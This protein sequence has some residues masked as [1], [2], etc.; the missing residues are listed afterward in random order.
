MLR[1]CDQLS[2][3]ACH[4]AALVE[5]LSLDDFLA[6]HFAQIPIRLGGRCGRFH[7]LLDW[8]ELARL[9]ETHPLDHS[10]LRLI[11]RGKDI[12]P[13]RY[14]R[15]LGGIARLDSGALSL[16]LD[17]GATLVVNHIDDLVPG[18]ASIADDVADRLGARV[19]V[20]LYASWRSDP[21]FGAHWDHHDILVLQL[22]GAKTWAIHKPVCANP[23][24]G[25]FHRLDEGAEPDSEET[26]EDGHVLYLPRGWIHSPTPAG[27]PSLHLTISITRPKG[28]SFLEWLVEELKGDPDVRANIPFPTDTKAWDDWKRHIG[29][30][31]MRAIEGQAAERYVAHK[32][33]QRGARPRLSFP[34]F[35]RLQPAD[36][37]DSTVLRPASLHRVPVT[38]ASDGTA[39]IK[40]LGRSWPCSV[41]VARAICS[42]SSTSPMSLGELQDGLDEAQTAELRAQISRLATVGLL[43]AN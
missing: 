34:D 33:S 20:N 26:L 38:E 32:D 36:W 1:R 42:L 22:A 7:H 24:Q 4:L 15:I 9:L 40:A 25:E 41:A 5:P 23:L 19:V 27:E 12:P 43:S 13:E 3:E 2:S 30:I 11:A 17:S 16:L 6:H 35:G 39:Q 14:T 18:V 10:R 37:T 21:G 29:A 8:D 28:S 31:V